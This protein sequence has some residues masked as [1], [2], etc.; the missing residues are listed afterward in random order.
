MPKNK[1][2]LVVMPMSPESRKRRRKVVPQAGG[3]TIGG[4]VELLRGMVP[5]L[6][7]E[8]EYCGEDIEDRG[9]DFEFEGDNPTAVAALEAVLELPPVPAGL[10]SLPVDCPRMDW[11]YLRWRVKSVGDQLEAI[12]E[13]IGGREAGEFGEALDEAWGWFNEF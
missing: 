7:E 5:G 9:D 3:P 6:L 2:S 8:V 1:I 13:A 4:Q 12:L 10:T 11:E